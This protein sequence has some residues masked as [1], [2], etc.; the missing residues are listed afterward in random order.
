MRVRDFM[1]VEPALETASMLFLDRLDLR[2][3]SCSKGYT[4]LQKND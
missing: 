3:A 4:N 1:D 2:Y